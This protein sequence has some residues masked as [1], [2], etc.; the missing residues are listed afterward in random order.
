MC[1][2]KHRVIF[3]SRWVLFHVDNKINTRL[4]IYLCHQSLKTFMKKLLSLLLAVGLFTSATA[5]SNGEMP[6][7]L[8]CVKI[9]PI[10]LLGGTIKVQYE[11]VIHPKMTVGLHVRYTLPKKYTSSFFYP[12]DATYTD[13]KFS[14]LTLTPEFRYY[15]KEAMR[16]FYIAPYLR[17]RQVNLDFGYPIPSNG[18]LTSGVFNGNFSAY[19]GGLMIGV[20]QHLGNN[21]SLDF[22]IIGLQIMKNKIDMSSTYNL[23]LTAAEQAD[24]LADINNTIEGADRFIKDLSVVVGPNS[25]NLNGS[26]MGLGFRGLSLSLGYRF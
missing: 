25:A 17:Y 19:G 20:H 14:A 24:L 22:S 4:M 2:R 13:L 3:I 5:Q 12:N 11:R 10:S 18:V 6:E 8:N 15:V 23:N 9:S 26:Y 16:G 1:E 21:F 7:K